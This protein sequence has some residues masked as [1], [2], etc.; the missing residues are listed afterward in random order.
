[1]KLKLHGMTGPL[2]SIIG[3]CVL[4]QS[5]QAQFNYTDRDLLLTFRKIQPGDVGTV[6]LEVDIGQAS[7]YYNASPGS[8]FQITTY[9]PN[10][11]LIALLSDADGLGNLGW[12]IAG[13][14]S[15]T[16]DNGSDPSKP[17]D[18]LW[19]TAPC[20]DPNTP[21]PA[22]VEKS[23][24]QQGPVALKITSI[25]NNAATWGES[26]HTD[27]VTNTATVAAIPTSS[28]Q[29][30]N[31]L[32][33]DIG[34]LGSFWGNIENTTPS[35]FSTSTFATPARSDLYELKPGSGNGTF[36]GYFLLGTDGTLT[37]NAPSAVVSFP[38]P[39]LTIT[40]DGAGNVDIS[41]QST[42][43]GTYTLYYTSI[44]NITAP[45][46]TWSTASSTITGDGTV[47]TFVQPINASGT[48]T[49]YSV[50]VQ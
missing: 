24:Y 18:T 26:T 22:W 1:M 15:P 37:F 43:G 11:Q 39:T 38:A 5:A 48:G 31:N 49:V 2:L 28:Q 13:C 9:D 4:L 12:S 50:G 6:D 20:V 27:S 42:A 30:D 47:Q 32:L 10:N 35:T 41:Y 33:S 21:A 34:N 3:S 7:T 40:N 25:L 29:A 17:T 14:V 19:V 23:I 46:S 36:L 16:Q 44:N 8:S 45:I